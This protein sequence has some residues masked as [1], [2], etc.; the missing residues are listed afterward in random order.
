[1]QPQPKVSMVVPCYNKAKYI[2]GMLDSVIAQKWDNIELIL[3][4]DGSNDGTKDRLVEYESKLIARGFEIKMIDQEN[5]GVA[6]AVR[7]GLKL[8]TGEFVCMPDCDDLLHEEYVSAMVNALH[9]FPNVNCVVCDQERARW[10]IWSIPKHGSSEIRF[11]SNDQQILL[12]KF[13]LKTLS[14][15]VCVMMFRASLLHKLRITENFI[16][17]TT[18]EPQI[19]LPILASE[20]AVIHLNRPLYS[21]IL[22][23]NSLETSITNIQKIYQY[24]DDRYLLVQDIL[25][26]M[27]T[28]AKQLD[29]Y[30]KLANI[31]KYEMI[32]ARISWN[33]H[34]ESYREIHIKQFVEF[35][36]EIGLLSN[37]LTMEIVEDVGFFN[38]Y[39]FVCDYLTDNTPRLN[40]TLSAIRK[41]QG[42]L[43]A[44][45]AGKVATRE[46]PVFIRHHA[47]PNIVW[48]MKASRDDYFFEVPIM[49]PDFASLTKHDTVIIFLHDHRDVVEKLLKTEA[50]I[51]YYQDVLR[52]FAAEY[53]TEPAENK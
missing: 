6:A 24:A 40:D 41:T 23:E 45:G 19:W 36:N 37:K 15:S 29:Y 28:S 12:K 4:N 21:Y 16:T 3:V 14:Q 39:R 7:N 2:A 50:N 33:S 10:E 9:Q 1:M 52:A 8:V 11:I 34:L 47:V 44:Y 49:Q 17:S 38:V 31:V 13:V 48:D 26:S 20:E 42:R 35:V 5:Q 22:R 43:I 27:V 18:Q 53:F 25:K 51:L 46:F 32:I 30:S